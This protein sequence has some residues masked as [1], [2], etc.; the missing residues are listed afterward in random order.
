MPKVRCWK[1][2]RP[3]VNSCI[4]KKSLL[5][6]NGNF[7]LSRYVLFSVHTSPWAKTCYSP[8]ISCCFSI[9]CQKKIN[10]PQIRMWACLFVYSN[11]TCEIF[12]HGKITR[13]HYALA[14]Q[15]SKAVR[16]MSL[17]YQAGFIFFIIINHS[18][19]DK[20][21]ILPGRIQV[22]GENGRFPGALLN[23]YRIMDKG[24]IDQ[25]ISLYNCINGNELW[26]FTLFSPL[27]IDYIL[28]LRIREIWNIRKLFWNLEVVVIKAIHNKVIK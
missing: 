27:W 24:L 25:L 14:V 9:I 23:L 3:C 18:Q 8:S 5:L 13:T 15:V 4:K 21:G 12:Q 26:R 1:Y 16:T 2:P 17:I 20:F 6:S 22:D 19:M 11:R 10:A 28:F 7:S